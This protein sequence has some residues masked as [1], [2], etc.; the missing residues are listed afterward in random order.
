M[1]EVEKNMEDELPIPT[2]W[3]ESLTKIAN[4]FVMR[5]FPNSQ[6]N[7]DLGDWRK[8]ILPINYGNIDDYPDELGPLKST[9]WET[10]I[11]LWEETHWVVLLDL[12][13]INGKTTDLV[14]HLEVKEQGDGFKFE[15]GLIYV[16]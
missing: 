7:P 13:D 3:R 15:P 10:S 8:N 14:L 2:L 6:I 4:A 11:Y 9:T 12:S 5:N 16:P 1:I